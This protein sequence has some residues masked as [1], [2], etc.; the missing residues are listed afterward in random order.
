MNFIALILE[1]Y[2]YDINTTACTIYV[3]A[4]KYHQKRSANHNLK[5]WH[6]NQSVFISLSRKAA[7]SLDTSI[8]D[9]LPPSKLKTHTFIHTICIICIICMFCRPNGAVL[10]CTYMFFLFLMHK[11]R[12]RYFG[13]LRYA[14]RASPTVCLASNES[15]RVSCSKRR[16]YERRFWVLNNLPV[17]IK[18]PSQT[19]S[20]WL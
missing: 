2:H 1:S 18:Q 9:R 13:R 7:R 17:Y 15:Y 3:T 11:K 12:T 6:G 16:F 20:L 10:Y 14:I 4:Q 5:K 19:G 8:V